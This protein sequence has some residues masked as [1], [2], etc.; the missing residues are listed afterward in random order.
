[1]NDWKAVYREKLCTPEEAVS[2]IRDGE[3]VLVGGVAARP[4]ALIRALIKNASSYRGVRIMHGLSSGGEEYLKEQYKENFIHETLFVSASTRKAVN[5]GR[6]A[7]YPCYYY[8]IGSLLKDGD[9]PVDVFMFQ[10]S[11]PDE[12]G[13]CSCGLMADFIRE[14]IET[15]DRVLLQVNEKMPRNASM[16]TVIHV[17]EADRIVA[18]DEP[19]PSFPR[20]KITDIEKKIGENC[21]SLV[22][23]GSTIQIGIGSIPDAVCEA[24]KGKKNLG[25]HSELI[26][27]GIMDLYRSGAITNSEKSREKRTM[28]A[29]FL[30]G[31][32][33]LYDF[34]D[35]NR[36]LTLKSAAYVNGPFTIAKCSK[37]VSINTCIEADLMGQVVSGSSGLRNI[38]GS[39][40]QLDFVRGAT[41]S[42]DRKGKAI[43]AMTS[44]HEKNGV[45]TSRIKPF[46]TDGSSVTVTR[47]DAEYFVTEY[48]IANVK[49]KTL[50]DRA[51]A[52]IEI[53]HPDFR[54]EL[55]AEY[56]R[57]FK[58]P[59]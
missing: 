44:V 54:P 42:L 20:T 6:A 49:G 5:E 27:D 26:S 23:D 31:T 22:E 29:V 18:C 2:L 16:D 39:G 59:Y 40:G 10:A 56:E 47:Q 43:I 13:Y 58:T 24:L 28:T 35:N 41:M 30:M 57:R 4:E 33:E 37:L 32:Q 46:I 21:A 36:A 8:E 17:S 7:V 19:M 52:M 15:A 9:I 51:R 53:A 11:P 1:M 25:V 34:A 55:Q 48:G 12:H 50:K 38:S 45:R 14:G 3:R